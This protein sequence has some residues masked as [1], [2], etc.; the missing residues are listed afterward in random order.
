MRGFFMALMKWPCKRMERSA[1]IRTEAQRGHGRSVSGARPARATLPLPAQEVLDVS[2]QPFR[3]ELSARQRL[4]LLGRRRV[5]L[6]LQLPHVLSGGAVL[7]HRSI[8]L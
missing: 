4:L 1:G 7:S 5:V 2:H 8:T 6:L 3:V